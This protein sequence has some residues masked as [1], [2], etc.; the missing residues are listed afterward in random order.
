MEGRDRVSSPSDTAGSV[1]NFVNEQ[2]QA[3]IYNGR[4]PG[5]RAPPVTLFNKTLA[6]LQDEVTETKGPAPDSRMLQ[7][8]SE[9]FSKASL[10]F[11]T[12]KERQQYMKRDY[13]NLLDTVIEPYNSQLGIES[14]PDGC[15]EE[16][17]DND[18]LALIFLEVE[19]MN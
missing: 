9:L 17:L 10:V 5:L 11:D 18:M 13:S 1:T 19:K 12:Q 16:E 8:V 3:P 7:L 4:P 2:D 14:G 15:V 6:A